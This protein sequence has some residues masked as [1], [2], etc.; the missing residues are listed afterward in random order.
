MNTSFF[1]KLRAYIRTC[2][3]FFFGTPRRRVA[4]FAVAFL[5]F[6]LYALIF[7]PPQHFPKGHI[8]AVDRGMT[9]EGVAQHFEKSGVV[10]S[11]LIFRSAVILL[12]GERRTHAGDYFFEEP[13]GVLSVA[14]RVAQGDFRLTPVV[15]RIPEGASAREIAAILEDS[16]DTFDTGLFLAYA[17]ADEGYLFPDTYHFLPNATESE[18]YQALKDNFYRRTQEVK[19]EIARFGRPFDDV[20]TMASIIEL[21]GDDL[22]TKRKIASV[23]WNR[24]GIGMALQVDASF[25]YILGKGTAQLSLEDLETDSPYNTYTHAG[26]PPGPISNPSLESILAAVTPIETDYLY[27]LAD[28]SGVTHFSKTFDEHTRKKARYLP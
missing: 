17:A 24:I 2:N 16:L 27:Y 28:E 11:P 10:R 26:L 18:V 13:A 9:L 6:S 21:E 8:V 20:I 1:G 5:L 14:Y 22:E 19:E 7:T 23:L 4:S 15:V 12:G 3:N 25:V